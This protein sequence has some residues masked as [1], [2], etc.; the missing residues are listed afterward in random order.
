MEVIIATKTI[1]RAGSARA[2]R[3][4]RNYEGLRKGGVGGTEAA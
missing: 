3:R 2:V 1:V 4:S